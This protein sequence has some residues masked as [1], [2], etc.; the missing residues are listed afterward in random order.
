MNTRRNQLF[1][2]L[3][4]IS[5][6]T[7]A[8]LMVFNG[9]PV[10][11]QDGQKL[12]VIG[13][14]EDAQNQPVSGASVALEADGQMLSEASSQADGRFVLSIPQPVP[15]NF[16]IYITRA[17]FQ[18]TTLELNDAQII[19]LQSGESVILD[20]I[21]LNREIGIAFWIAAIIFVVVLVLIASGVIHNT[22]AAL[23]GASLVLGISYLGHPIYEGLYIFD[24][25]GSIGYIDWNVIFLIMGMM[26]FIAIVE[27]TGIFQWMAFA[28]YR[29]SKGK[30]LLLLP[31]LMFIT[32]ISSAFL[33]NV[34]TMLLMT[35]IT[36]QIAL[37]V[38]ITPLAL[39]I[40]EVMASN[41]IGVS[42][43]VGTPTNILIGS[44]GGITFNGFLQNLT[45]GVLLAF[46]GLVIYNSVIYRKE[47][48]EAHGASE[49][50]LAILEE[51]GKITHPD[52]LKKAGWI[53]ALMLLMFIFG[54]KIHMLPSV[55]AL[56]GA[57]ALLL[58]IRPN[59]EEMIEAVDWTTLVFFMTLFIV[60]GAVQ[61][62]GVISVIAGWIGK[63]VG[64]NL[65][66]AMLA[67]TWLSALLSM[68][69]ANI[70]FT[71][72]MLPVVGFLTTTVP[73]A[74][75]KVLF[76][77]L[78]IGAA[79]GG[80]GSLIGASANLVTAGIADAAGYRISY[81]YFLKKGLPA[82]LITV[83]LAFLW[84]V[85]RFA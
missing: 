52:H 66:L 30:M 67:I 14:I 78:S 44:Y 46:I 34:T 76:F 18:E 17:H 10:E 51:R 3:I 45:P 82:V 38:E 59:I 35:P 75:S 28:A 22:L 71:A 32:G 11:A 83:G 36:V 5:L 19:M 21:T 43:L 62:V 57:T 40:P 8:I 23:I 9:R 12:V 63:M 4:A 73:G 24:F 13:A 1:S 84:L 48:N 80:N 39:L 58:W 56:I 49:T 16:D 25:A 70:P 64:E 61:E 47:L 60:V 15:E 69:I 79:M 54:E 74:E 55:T 72:A 81:K 37:A 27:H 50:L 53:G 26:M 77:C 29:V 6:L 68:V 42:T 7:V 31:I 33:D 2:T 20:Q 41:V 85:I 65:I